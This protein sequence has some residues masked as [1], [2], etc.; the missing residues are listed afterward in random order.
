MFLN[1]SGGNWTKFAYVYVALDKTDSPEGRANATLIAAAPEL[2]A[3]CKAMLKTLDEAQA[4]DFAA[5]LAAHRQLGEA[6]RK[7]TSDR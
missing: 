6:V 3:A 1:G 5:M 2:L 7:A 4:G